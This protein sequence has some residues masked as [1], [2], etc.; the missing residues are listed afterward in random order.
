MRWSRE[1]LC[2]PSLVSSK[3][4]PFDCDFDHQLLVGGFNLPL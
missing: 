2:H 3:V 1:A 4:P